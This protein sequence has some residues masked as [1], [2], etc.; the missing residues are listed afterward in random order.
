MTCIR[1]AALTGLATI[2]V[3]LLAAATAGA[4]AGGLEFLSSF[5]APGA[6]FADPNAIAVNQSNG[7]VYVVDNARA[8]DIFNSAGVFQS[9]LTGP[10]FEGLVNDVAVDEAT[11]QIFVVNYAL[12]V[13]VYS[14]AG[15]HEAT[16]TGSNTPLGDL[17]ARGNDYVAVDNSQSPS[18]PSAGDVYVA[19]GKDTSAF[20]DA[21][22]GVV[23][24]FNA[25]G[26]WLSQFNGAERP[27]GPF[28]SRVE[29]PEG[30]G[31]IT[32]DSNG[33]VYLFEQA[34]GVIDQFGPEGK[35]LHQLTALPGVRY[36]AAPAG[37]S[38]VYAVAGANVYLL[39]ASGALQWQLLGTAN[40]PF[41]EPAAIAG[42]EATGDAYLSE[43]GPKVVD[44][45]GPASLPPAP[46]TEPPTGNVGTSVVAHGELNPGGVSTGYFFSYGKGTS[47]VGNQTA[48]SSAGSGSSAV[49]EEATLALEPDTQYTYCLSAVVGEIA[50]AGSPV[51][52]TTTALAP[53][54][55]ATNVDRT[56]AATILEAQVNPNKQDATCL[57][58]YGTTE[59]YGSSAPCEPADLGSEYAPQYATLTLTGLPVA[60]LYHYRVVTANAT[61]TT[62]SSDQT[63]RTL[64]SVVSTGAVGAVGQ[65]SASVAGTVNPE[66]AETHYY[67]QYGTT[68]EYGQSTASEGEGISAGSG[69]SAV[70]APAT[71]VPLVPGVTYHYRLVAWNEYATTYG[72][73][74]TFTTQ[75]GQPPAATTGAASGVSVDE[76]T[77][78]G[79]VDPQGKETSYRFEYGATTE[80]GTQA[81]GTVLPEYG[82][83]TVTLSLRGIDPD[84]TYHYRLVVSNPGG[85]SY[86]E[87]AT[88]TTAPIAFPL[89][90]PTPVPILALP[91][92]A[93]P[94]GSQAATQTGKAKQKAHKRKR[95]KPS[96]KGKGKRA[97]GRKK[98]KGK[99]G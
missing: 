72:E 35:Y 88:F 10:A 89:I 55:E 90:A 60:T 24:K 76:A 82:V 50:R 80:Y 38:G 26:E 2:A 92:I 97:A 59:A 22:E 20:R 83:Q 28:P 51:T 64:G 98:K 69:M 25:E 39:D 75:A 87:D 68:T 93:F 95:K 44:R 18:D 79:T 34:S 32:V 13:E 96:K 40:G 48:L 16:W 85:T 14:S 63:F 30:L 84:T 78:S 27:E 46:S 29:E 81:F 52:F 3:S 71:L 66:G 61:G 15:V 37:G 70:E 17:G 73:D 6:G 23:E 58:E 47:C 9:A 5:N 1:R 62:R 67:Y 86:G 19:V 91:S 56:V 7:D 42:N 43:G 53:A 54:I 8:V 74:E 36:V 94:T 45:F 41:S 65:T 57:I 31:G 12:Q 11:G 4:A 33:D 49:S 21:G 99:K 77:I